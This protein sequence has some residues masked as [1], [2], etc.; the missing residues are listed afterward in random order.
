[1]RHLQGP[2]PNGM[3][4]CDLIRSVVRA[5]REH[6]VRRDAGGDRVG[7]IQPGLKGWALQRQVVVKH[8]LAQIATGRIQD[9]EQ[10]GAAVRG[11]G[12]FLAQAAAI[13]RNLSLANGGHLSGKSGV[14][15]A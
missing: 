6:L 15:S 13:V 11:D 12:E 2:W 14:G 3:S 4:G 1:M 10:F 9:V 7:L 8:R 5:E